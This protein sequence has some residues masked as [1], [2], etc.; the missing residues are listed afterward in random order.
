MAL[1]RL[2]LHRQRH[3]RCLSLRCRCRQRH[4]GWRGHMPHR[5]LQRLAISRLRGSSH[6]DSVSSAVQ[7][8]RSCGAREVRCNH[9][10]RAASDGCETGARVPAGGKKPCGGRRRAR[11]TRPSPGRSSE[12]CSTPLKPDAPSV[13]RRWR[14]RTWPT[15]CTG[16][17]LGTRSGR[18]SSSSPMLADRLALLYLAHAHRHQPCA[19]VH[20]AGRH[21][22]SRHPQACRS[23]RCC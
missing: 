9:C 17:S 12:R 13:E 21:A 1:A 14:S 16:R 11:S 15:S 10:T 8:S 4:R 23:R 19:A 5:R 3:R 18:S 7:A 20:M 2:A 22:C 6:I